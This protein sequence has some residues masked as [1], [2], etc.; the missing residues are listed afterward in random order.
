MLKKLLQTAAVVLVAAGMTGVSAA[1][2]MSRANGVLLTSQ[3]LQAEAPV[4]I[5]QAPIDAE[6]LAAPVAQVPAP[7]AIEG[8]ARNFR[9][10]LNSAGQLIGQMNVAAADAINGLPNLKVAVVQDGAIRAQAT[11]NETG[12]FSIS[13][14]VPGVYTLV[15]SGAGGYVT[16]GLQVMPAVAGAAAAEGADDAIQDVVYQEVESAVEIDSLAVP[17][18]DFGAVATLMRGYIPSELLSGNAPATSDSDSALGADNSVDDAPK[19]SDIASKYAVTIRDGV[20]YGRMRRIHPRTGERLRIRRL[21]VFLVQNGDVVSQATVSDTGA[22]AFPNVEPGLHSFVAVGAEGMSAF[23]VNAIDRTVASADVADELFMP[24]LFQAGGGEDLSGTLGQPGDI[25]Q[26]AQPLGV[27]GGQQGGPG[28][29]PPPGP[30]AGGPGGPG[31][32]GFG[33]GGAGGGFG[34]GGAGGGLGGGGGLGLLAAGLGAAA[35]GVAL[36]DDDEIISPPGP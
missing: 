16:Y 11:T 29:G 7:E 22:F 20:V 10:R 18:S 9:V 31:G 34:G 17:P 28:V 13:G 32:G 23:A 2:I 1:V 8:S 26:Q 21:N 5:G 36:A 33:G 3:V 35:L 4:P 27:N 15:G 25:A 30:L 19:S 12:R 14:L 6:S 24:V